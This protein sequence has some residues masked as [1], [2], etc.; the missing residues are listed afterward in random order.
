MVEV[1]N[2][3]SAPVAAASLYPI[4]KGLHEI[5]H[6]QLDL[7][8]DDELDA[9]IK[10]PAPVTSTKNIW[11]FWDGGYDTLHPYAAR[12]VRTWHRRFSK[13]GWTVRVI[14]LVP[15]SAGYV[16]RWLDLEDPKVVPQAFKERT[17]DGEFAKQHYSD[18]VRFP[19]LLRYGGVY[20]DVG[21]MQIGD[22][23]AL[24][25]KTVG[26]PHSP[27]EVISYNAGGPQVYSLMNYFIGS[28][29]D[30]PLWQGC[31][32]LLLKLWE[33]KTSTEG[34][35][36]HPLLKGLKLLGETFDGAKNAGISAKL[37]DYII[38]GQAITMALRT[39]DEARNWDGPAYTVEKVY[40]PDYI[41]G[42]QLINDW[43]EWN[44]QKAYELMSL[45]MPEVGQPESTN[46]ELARKIVE[47]CLSR[48]FG[49]K[50]AHGLIIQVYGDTLG[51]LWRKNPGSDVVEGTYAH[52]LRYGMER[53]SQDQLPERVVFEKLEPVKKGSLL[54]E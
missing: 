48:S 28:L 8:S 40:A 44:G 50:L 18:L 37:T 36:N 46:Q 6:S 49:F 25:E 21:F 22:L 34:M 3:T 30:N 2:N 31:H 33:G 15:D 43:T 53:W 38:Q 23:D 16:G 10:N 52:W 13:K 41:V 20:T 45:K 7:R 24:W 35:R 26:D 1:D 47:D 5:P 17:L 29:P 9:V 19:L 39:V 32:G 14:D 27:Y 4:P 12:T 51:S 54:E 11:F 42:S